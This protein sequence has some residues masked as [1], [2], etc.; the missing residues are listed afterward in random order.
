MSNAKRTQSPN[1]D[2][3]TAARAHSEQILK[4]HD[5]LED[6]HPVI[7]L[8]FQRLR[9]HSYPFA[10]YKATI[11]PESQAMLNEE[12]EKAVAKNKVLVVVWDSE[13]RRLAT[14]RIRRG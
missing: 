6:A 14:T 9:L 3:V 11:R 12:Y 13:T 2:L 8:D 7:V 5:Q 10:E 4:F 1:A